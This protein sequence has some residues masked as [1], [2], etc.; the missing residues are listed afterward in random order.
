M[1]ITK[2]N[3]K[4]AIQMLESQCPGDFGSGRLSPNPFNPN[5]IFYLLST[6]DM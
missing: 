3:T 6:S 4:D 1:G 5:A 2:C